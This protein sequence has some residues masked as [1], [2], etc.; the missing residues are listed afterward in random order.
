MLCA[1]LSNPYQVTAS[2]ALLFWPKGFNPGAY[3]IVFRNPDVATGYANTLFYVIVGTSINILLTVLAAYVLSR[4]WVY[5]RNVIM[6]LITFTMFFGGG[7]IPNYL[8]VKNLH[9]MDTRWALILPNAVAVWN[10]IIMRTYFNTIPD[11]M[12][13]SAKIDGATDMTV[14]FRI[15][16]PLSM[17]VIAVMILFYAVGQWNSWFPAVIFLR[18]RELFPL[19]LILREVLI[20][21]DV[22]KVMK[23]ADI[24]KGN[25]AYF[26]MLVKY[27]TIVVA[28]LPVIFVY[29]FLQKYFISGIMIGSIKE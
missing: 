28:T 20:Q 16:L 4:K 13:E 7:L 8:L 26:R 6:M 19:Q 23:V 17:P 14:L 27:S 11:S 15:I 25:D 18:K 1:S 21:N 24:E 12:E 9:L 29:P 3:R 10:I 22:T 5:G 2:G